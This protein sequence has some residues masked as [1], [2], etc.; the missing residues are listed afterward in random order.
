LGGIEPE[1][2]INDALSESG[3]A[4]HIDLEHQREFWQNEQDSGQLN[5]VDDSI[6]DELIESDVEQCAGALAFGSIMGKVYR[7]KNKEAQRR[8]VGNVDGIMNYKEF[9]VHHASTD[10][11]RRKSDGKRF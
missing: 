5:N 4:C 10:N 7:N 11:F 8:M 1:Q 2:F 3:N 9:L 6:I